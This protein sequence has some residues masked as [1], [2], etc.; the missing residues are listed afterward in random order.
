[1][2]LVLSFWVQW[3]RL[4]RVVYLLASWKRKF[5]GHRSRQ[6]WNSL[7]FRLYLSRGNWVKGMIYILKDLCRCTGL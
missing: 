7:N 6:V 2:L 5:G 3:V 1:M 4:K